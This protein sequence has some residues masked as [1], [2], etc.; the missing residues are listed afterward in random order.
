MMSRARR[1]I[2]AAAA[3]VALLS[4]AAGPS[5][6]AVT[7]CFRPVDIEA[8]QAMRFQTQLMV[9]SDTC[10]GD[11]YRE[12]TVRNRDS[13]IFYQHQLLDHYRL[14]GARSP[15]AS[16]D[17]YLTRIANEVSLSNGQELARVVCGRSATFLAEARTLDGVQFRHRA[18]EMAAENEASYRRCQ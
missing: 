10:G 14:T 5:V 18:A 7:G 4:S 11:T 13:I 3:I 17:T 6:A 1:K 12:F 9:L 15:E 16:L 2:I 8:E